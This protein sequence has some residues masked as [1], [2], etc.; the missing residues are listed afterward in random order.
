M[1]D[2]PLRPA[3]HQSLGGPL[4]HQLANETQAHLTAKA[5]ASSLSR[6]TQ[7][8]IPSLY[9]VLASL[10]AGYSRQSGR[11]PTC[12]S[13]VRHFTQVTLFTFDLHV[14]GTPPAFALSQD[15]TLMFNLL[16]TPGFPG[17][18]ARPTTSAYPRVSLIESRSQTVC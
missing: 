15:Q 4:P 11:L 6:K 16:A 8:R 12:Y 13:P 1:A 5:L 3:T 7:L 9:P 18:V 17:V 2:H 14:L 10:S